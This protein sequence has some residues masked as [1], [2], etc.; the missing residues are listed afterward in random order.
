MDVGLAVL[1]HRFLLQHS[2]NAAAP[3]ACVIGVGVF[4]LQECF[5][6]A[7]GEGS[8]QRLGQFRATDRVDVVCLPS[9]WQVL[10]HR[11]NP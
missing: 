1:G 2:Q 5:H 9:T 10:R 11:R 7:A 4:T 6:G 3:G 8:G